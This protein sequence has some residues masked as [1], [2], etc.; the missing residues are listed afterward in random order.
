M[1]QKTLPIMSDATGQKIASAIEGVSIVPADRRNIGELV[2]SSLP[3]ND[4]NL[5]LADGTY[6]AR[7]AYSD[8]YDYV[9]SLYNLGNQAVVSYS[10]WADS[11]AANGGPIGRY[12][13]DTTNQRIYLPDFSSTFVEGTNTAAELGSFIAAGV[14]NIEGTIETT[15]A[16][17]VMP[18]TSAGTYTGAFVGRADSGDTVYSGAY[19]E[20]GWARGFEFDA[21]QSNPI[22][23]NSTTVQPQAIK[24]YVYIV[25][26][27]TYRAPMTI[28]IDEVMTDIAGI[29][30]DITDIQGNVTD[31]SA[32]ID[33]F[34][35]I[36]ITSSVTKSSKITDQYNSIKFLDFPAFKMIYASGLPGLN[37]SVSTNEV[38][39]TFPS[40]YRSPHA[41]QYLPS[42]NLSKTLNGIMAFRNGTL[43]VDNNTTFST[44]DYFILNHWFIYY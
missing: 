36:D 20:G 26:A 12:G 29:Q 16:R 7:G 28:A 3:L 44:T 23:G 27:N 40:K 37:S 39:W 42:F 38:L 24:Q 25:V 2:F 13:V 1:A 41:Y 31:L 19:Q 30:S 5:H 10:S 8:F 34:K 4:A 14:P 21:S 9:L 35:P 17:W 22:Y 15:R 6:I 33:T 32:L 18:P 43:C 11:K